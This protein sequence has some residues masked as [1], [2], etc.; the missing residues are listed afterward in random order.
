MS[1]F[2]AYLVFQEGASNAYDEHCADTSAVV[3]K[4]RD[5]SKQFHSSEASTTA[6]KYTYYRKKRLMR[7]KFESSPHCSNSVDYAFQTPLE[8]SKKQEAAGDLSKNTEVQ[9][10]AVSSEKIGKRKVLTK[11]SPTAKR[12]SK[13]HNLPCA[14]SSAKGP[15][16]A[17]STRGRKV[18]K[19]P[20]AVQSMLFPE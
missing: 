14:A 13:K 1:S 4:I 9:S 10:T 18:M 19:V 20:R 5:R 6:E 17:K 7:K 11:S 12:S 8:K 15:S 3:D 2:G 16:S